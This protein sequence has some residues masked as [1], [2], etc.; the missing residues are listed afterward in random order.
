MSC[1]YGQTDWSHM[2][3]NTANKPKYETIMEE[4]LIRI[5]NNDFSY[6]TAFAQRNNFPH[7]TM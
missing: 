7:N 1:P 3:Q 2:E 5:H 6:D 4:L